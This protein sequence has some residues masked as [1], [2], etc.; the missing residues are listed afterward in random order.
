MIAMK[1]ALMN[2]LRN[3][4]PRNM[5]QMKSQK[6]MNMMRKKNLRRS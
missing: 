2:R 1:P 4:P 6:N 3:I 5:T